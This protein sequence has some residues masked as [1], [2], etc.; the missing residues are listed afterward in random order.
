MSCSI[1]LYVSVSFSSKA[2]AIYKHAV[3]TFRQ[4]TA[5]DIKATA[6]ELPTQQGVIN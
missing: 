3:R 6:S 1:S 5:D 2:S 4:T